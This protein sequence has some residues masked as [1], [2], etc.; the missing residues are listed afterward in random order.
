MEVKRVQI[1]RDFSGSWLGSRSA[2]VKQFSYNP[3]PM[4]IHQSCQALLL[5]IITQLFQQRPNHQD[6]FLFTMPSSL[7]VADLKSFKMSLEKCVILNQLSWVCSH[8]YKPVGWLC[9]CCFWHIW[10]NMVSAE[11]WRVCAQSVCGEG[12]TWGYQPALMVSTIAS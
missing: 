3:H 11:G 2:P 5:P 1:Y 9:M 7:K 12:R 4:Q 6:V 8:E 10:S